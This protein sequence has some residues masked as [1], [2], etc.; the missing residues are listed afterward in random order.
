MKILY[1]TL[2]ILLFLSMSALAEQKYNAMENRWETVPDNSN[3]QTKYNPMENDWSYQPKDAK[4]E[5]NPFE[6]K[7]EWDSGH[8]PEQKGED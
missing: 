3:W 7:W 5:Y 4:T 2:A 6:N 8:N 1:L